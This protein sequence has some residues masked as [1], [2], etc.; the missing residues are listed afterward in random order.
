[1][2]PMTTLPFVSFTVLAPPPG[3]VPP[4]QAAAAITPASGTAS[5]TGPRICRPPSPSLDAKVLPELV[6]A[7]LHFV[8]REGR[9]DLALPE[10]IVAVGHRGGNTD[11]LL[12]Q[13]ERE[14]A[15][16]RVPD[17]PRD[18]RDPEGRAPAGRV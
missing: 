9:N 1:M 11:V 13:E 2:T 12:D 15:G 7:R 8:V 18:V 14:R 4:P 17:A 5:Q 16:R 10:Q 3:V 6:L